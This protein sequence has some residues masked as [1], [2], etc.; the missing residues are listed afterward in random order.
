MTAMMGP[1]NVLMVE[2]DERT[3]GPAGGHGRELGQP[4]TPLCDR[5]TIATTLPPAPALRDA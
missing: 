4:P 3:A 2:P 1:S 5:G